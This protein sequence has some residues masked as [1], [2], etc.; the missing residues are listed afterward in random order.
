MI[1]YFYVIRR[2]AETLFKVKKARHRRHRACGYEIN[3]LG[4]DQ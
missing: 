2:S 1:M 4:S 3:R